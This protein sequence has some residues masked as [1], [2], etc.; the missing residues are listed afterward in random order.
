MMRPEFYPQETHFMLQA[1]RGKAAGIVVKF[2]FSI[3]VLAF[4]VWGIGDYS[5]LRRADPTAV[6]IGDVKV[7]ASQLDQ[8]YRTEIDRLRRTLGQIDPETARQFGL[9]DQV[10]QRIV[11]R[12]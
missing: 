2:L 6:R 5:F 12:T 3:L 7:P 1:M 11:Y 4:A 9:M 8:Q 10:I